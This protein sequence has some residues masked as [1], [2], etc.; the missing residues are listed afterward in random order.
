MTTFEQEKQQLI[1][2]L[3][4]IPDGGIIEQVDPIGRQAVPQ[5][6]TDAPLEIGL[7]VWPFPL[8]ADVVTTL[9]TLGY[10]FLAGFEAG[11]VQKMVSKN[12]RFQLHIAA[13]G[14]SHSRNP[15]LLRDYLRHDKTARQQFLSGTEETK[16]IEQAHHWHVTH[17]GF[18]P[19]SKIV[20]EMKDYPHPWYISSGWALDLF[21]GQ[22]SRVHFDVDVI[23]R[24]RD[25]LTLQTHLWQRGWQLMTPLAGKYESWPPH[26]YLHL[27]RHQVHAFHE[28]GGFIDFLITDFGDGIWHYRRDPS[29]VQAIDR[30]SLT[31]EDGIPY[32]APELVLLSKASASYS[33]I[34]DH[35]DF[36]RVLP[37]L[38]DV[39]Q[40]WLRWALLV[41]APESPWIERL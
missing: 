27:P 39:Q 1:D 11:D 38:N 28:N 17:F 4:T 35:Q 18:D 25:Q 24:R 36:E 3:K 37:H 13:E 6:A 14:R 2:Q 16:L 22:V 15:I 32:L 9:N 29:I 41:T 26:M 31:N 7:A 40:A 10:A 33:R 19:L 5:L 21:L 30:I 12:G 20:A 8:E 34:K 23:I